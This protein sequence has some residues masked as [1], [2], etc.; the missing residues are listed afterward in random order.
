M[1]HFVLMGLV[2]VLAACSSSRE[3]VIEVNIDQ[4]TEID[5][6]AEAQDVQLEQGVAVEDSVPVFERSYEE[7]VY[8]QS[9]GSVQLFSLDSMPVYPVATPVTNVAREPITETV[10]E[11]VQPSEVKTVVLEEPV[12]E[13][14]VTTIFFEHNSSRLDREDVDIIR[15][16]A[17]EYDGGIV[18]VVGHASVDSRI[19][20]PVARKLSN[21]KVSVDRALSVAGAL[22]GSGLKPDAIKVSGR[23]EADAPEGLVSSD[24][25]RRVEI[26]Q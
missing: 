8:T 13:P 4:P 17:R 11:D 22:V 24:E 10:I 5:L 12:V 21:L 25:A 3:E 15:N 19:E 20:D 7:M 18:E 16:V 1:R 9:Q 6:M 23:G 26:V 14:S 2:F